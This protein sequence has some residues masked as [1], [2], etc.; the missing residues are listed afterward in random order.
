L[1]HLPRRA[2]VRQGEGQHWTALE[3]LRLTNRNS[4]MFDE[5]GL[6]GIGI[7]PPFAIQPDQETM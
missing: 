7:D 1:C 2:A 6:I 3:R 4:I 5:Q